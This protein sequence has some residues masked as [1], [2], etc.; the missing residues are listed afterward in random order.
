MHING[1]AFQNKLCKFVF[2]LSIRLNLEKKNVREREIT[3]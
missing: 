1:K 2:F 3:N